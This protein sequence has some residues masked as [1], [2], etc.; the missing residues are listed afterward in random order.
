[1]KLAVAEPESQALRAFLNAAG[2]EAVSLEI[3]DVEVRRA[4]RRLG[5]GDDAAEDV[6][7]AVTLLRLD[8]R[9]RGLASR[10]EPPEL[11]SLDALHLAAALGL[12]DDLEGVVVYDARLAAAWA[13]E[14]LALH[15][16]GAPAPAA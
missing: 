14:G 7:S 6:L 8:E 16:P 9:M 11:R 15:A 3:A 1:V 10:L 4:L 2:A 13:G 5:M 12:G